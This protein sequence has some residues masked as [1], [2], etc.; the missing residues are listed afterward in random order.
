MPCRRE[1]FLS[2]LRLWVSGSRQSLEEDVRE[3]WAPRPDLPSPQREMH[4]VL[5]GSGLFAYCSH[6]DKVCFINELTFSNSVPGLH[7]TECLLV[8]TGVLKRL[9]SLS[10]YFPPDYRNMTIHVHSTKL[11]CF[12]K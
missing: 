12:R 9:A 4:L 8:S 10:L 3:A 2:R 11:K 1:P 6:W 7:S 5:L